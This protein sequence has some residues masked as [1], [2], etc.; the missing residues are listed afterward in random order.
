MASSTCHV[1]GGTKRVRVERTVRRHARIV[2]W[3][4]LARWGQDKSCSA[5]KRS[6]ELRFVDRRAWELRYRTACVRRLRNC[7]CQLLALLPDRSSSW[8]LPSAAASWHYGRLRSTPI[9]IR[10][11][12]R[13]GLSDAWVCLC[14][15]TPDLSVAQSGHGFNRFFSGRAANHKSE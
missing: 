14:R 8:D 9:C 4:R 12:R 1:V 3:R 13:V 6:C 10:L 11:L 15:L 5:P 7:L 2:P